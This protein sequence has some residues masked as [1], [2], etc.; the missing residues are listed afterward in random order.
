M[1]SEKKSARTLQIRNIREV[2][3]ETRIFIDNRRT[4]KEKSLKVRS[5]KV[6]NC[7]MDGFDWGRIITIA[8]L[9]GSGKSTLLRQWIKEIIE[10]NKDEKFEVLSF[11]FEMLGIDEVARDLSSKLKTSVKKLYSAEDKL[12]ENDLRNIDSC[13]DE[14]SKYPI[15]IVD[16]LGSVPEIKDTIQYF[17]STNNLIQS[18][19][20]LIVTIDHSLNYWGLQQ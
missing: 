2:A 19:K 9:S 4:G 20:G 8:G 6:N 12:T 10:I 14:I 5:S 13:L 3:S 1:S 17:V 16:N 7:F 18:K 11:Q 15:N